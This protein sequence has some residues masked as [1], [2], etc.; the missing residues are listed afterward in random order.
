VRTS[1]FFC[2]LILFTL[3]AVPQ[4]RPG[5]PT[6]IAITGG[7]V[8]DVRTG[9]EISDATIL[10]E[11][12]RIEHVGTAHDLRK[13]R[14]ARILDASGRWIIPGLIDMHV[15]VS[16]VPDVPLELY[17]ANGVTAVRDLGGSLTALRLMRQDIERGHRLG[18]RLFLAGTILDGNPPVVPGSLMVD[19]P[20]QARSAVNFL[21]DQTADAIKVYNGITEPALKSILATAKARGVPVVGHVPQALTVLRAV[22]L[23]MRG[24]EHSPIRSRDLEAWGVVP[25]G[26]AARIRTMKSVSTREA[27]VWDLVDLGAPQVRMLLDTLEAFHVFLD[28]TLSIDEYDTLFLYD[29]EATHPNNRYLKRRFVEANSAAEHEDFR[30]PAHLKAVAAAG[31][32][33]RKAFVAMSHRAGVAILTGTDGPGI[34]RL[35]PGFGLHHELALLVEAGLSPLEALQAATYHAAQALRR[36]NQL[37]SLEAGKFADFVV[38]TA[39]PV[40]DIRNTTTIDAVVVGGRVLGRADLSELLARLEESARKDQPS[41][42]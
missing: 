31:L 42:R 9:K 29:V 30:V 15:H 24:I 33:K 12:D 8:L 7:T 25:P 11:G 1:A 27:L 37:G 26:E 16:T 2:P 36:E 40:A 17:V 22:Q 5:T 41:P 35:A 21:V 23:G 39:N 20:A 4:L 19:S 10:I 14:A 38:L 18:P 6:M 13:D 32:K 3:L 28:P 34:G